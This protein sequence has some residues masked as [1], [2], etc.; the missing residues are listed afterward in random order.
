MS[1]LSKRP[2]RAQQRRTEVKYG[3]M[4]RDWIA[5]KVKEVSNKDNGICVKHNDVRIV[6]K[7]PPHVWTDTATTYLSYNWTDVLLVQQGIILWC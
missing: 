2:S 4:L 5:M 1:N 7:A 3:E 6:R